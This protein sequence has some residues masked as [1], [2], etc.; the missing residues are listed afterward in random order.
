MRGSEV[1]CRPCSCVGRLS[2]AIH[3]NNVHG[4]GGMVVVA[5]AASKGGLD[6]R[7]RRGK[8]YYG[9][10]EK[11]IAQKNFFLLMPMGNAPCVRLLAYV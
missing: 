1:R 5:A 7:G 4:E 9:E 10:K 8:N 6:G 3:K 11:G 2:F